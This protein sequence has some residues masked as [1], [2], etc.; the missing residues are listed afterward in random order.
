MG[1]NNASAK[2]PAAQ[3]SRFRCPRRKHH[4]ARRSAVVVT[5]PRRQRNSVN[6]PRIVVRNI[7]K[8]GVDRFDD[9]RSAVVNHS[10]LWI[11]PQRAGRLR[12]HAHRLDRIHHIAR[13]VVISIAQGPRPAIV[14]SHIAQHRRKC[15]QGLNT[16]IPRHLV[17]CGG[18]LLGRHAGR[19]RH[20]V[21][22]VADLLRI[23]GSGQHLG[24]Q[25]VRVKSDRRD[26]LIELFG[27]ERR[28]VSRRRGIVSWRRRRELWA[29]SPGCVYG[30]NNSDNATAKH[31]RTLSLRKFLDFDVLSFIFMALPF[32]NRGYQ[33]KIKIAPVFRTF[34]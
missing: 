30:I 28:I 32:N 27:T 17:G 34:F 12:L 21:I 23:S 1:R 8:R 14:P 26:Q 6:R 29:N 22:G 2:C 7:D 33:T 20:P 18:T 31:P 10:F 24:N 9:H 13:L 5:A 3:G 25:C 11:R 19:L 15:R 16:R 4:A